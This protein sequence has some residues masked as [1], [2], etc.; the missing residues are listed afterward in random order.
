M[1]QIST[2]F[3]FAVVLALLT[4][5]CNTRPKTSEETTTTV[6]KD[7]TVKAKPAFTPY[8]ALMI[9]HTVADYDKW[10]AGFN[11]HALTLRTWAGVLITINKWLFIQ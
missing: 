7:T 11:A 6:T 10:L 1:K 9:L 2:I 3:T 5:S 8:K 4:T